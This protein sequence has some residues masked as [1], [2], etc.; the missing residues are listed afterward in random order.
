MTAKYI[1]ASPVGISIQHYRSGGGRGVFGDRDDACP[2][3]HG[4]A[5]LPLPC[6]RRVP[7]CQAYPGP[8][9]MMIP[10]KA[11]SALLEK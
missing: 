3:R 1:R 7:G 8:H 2:S 9:P 11:T 10:A 6:N 5:N 4:F